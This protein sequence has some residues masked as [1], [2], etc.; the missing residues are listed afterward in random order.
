[1]ASKWFS[2]LCFAIVPLF[3]SFG[4]DRSVFGNVRDPKTQKPVE[5]ICIANIRSRQITYTNKAG[6]FYLRALPGDSIIIQSFGYNRK[7]ILWDGK[8]KEVQIFAHQQINTLPE[9]IVYSKSTQELN[10]EIRRVFSETPD[11]DALKNQIIKDVFG[12]NATAS[13]M[14]GL[15]IS[16]DALYDLYSKEGKQRRKLADIQFLDLRN[17]YYDLKYSRGLVLQITH[18]EEKEISRFMDFCRPNVDFVLYANDYEL[19]KKIL[20]CLEAY[21]IRKIKGTISPIDE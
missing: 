11:G 1:M 13:G 21:N 10:E 18:L 5:N 4:Q 8:S 12:M 20:N 15:G 2:F 14:P 7:G 16:I 17:Y 6:D 9:L 3:S 19:T